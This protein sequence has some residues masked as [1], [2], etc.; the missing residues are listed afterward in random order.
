MADLYKAVAGTLIKSEVG[1]G[2]FISISGMNS[3]LNGG[4]MLVTSVRVNR[5]Q[6]VQFLKTLSSVFYIYAF[7]EAPGSV[8]VG[9]LIFFRECGG[10]V[11]GVIQEVNA[12]YEA[13]N[14]YARG[15]ILGVAVGGASF[16]CLL[17]ALSFSG[18]M[19]PYNYISFSLGFTLV[20]RS[21]SGG[22]AP[23]SGLNGASLQPSSGLQ[24][25]GGL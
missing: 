6:D 10:N 23:G 2:G 19:T 13:N 21:G 18:D 4:R 15:S 8:N 7:G 5:Q 17:T 25:S 9:G 22:D 20:P 14:A 3:L 11:S 16:P 1:G 12:F 24:T